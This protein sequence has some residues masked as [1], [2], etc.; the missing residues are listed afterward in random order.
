MPGMNGLELLRI[1]KK[2]IPRVKVMMVTAYGDDENYKQAMS[3]GADGFV[4]KPIDFNAL[5]SKCIEVAG[6]S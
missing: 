3:Y 4:N 1:L 2:E 5:K 6:G